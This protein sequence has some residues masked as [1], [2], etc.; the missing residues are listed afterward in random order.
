MKHKLQEGIE[1]WRQEVCKHFSCLLHI[2]LCKSS[3]YFE[4]GCLL[5]LYCVEA[6]LVGCQT[7]EAAEMRVRAFLERGFKIQRRFEY[8]VNICCKSLYLLQM[9]T[10]R[11]RRACFSNLFHLKLTKTKLNFFSVLFHFCSFNFVQGRTVTLIH[12]EFRSVLL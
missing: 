9:F 12:S 4:E 6:R 2:F 5:C 10:Y 3:P 7:E 1:M 8:S 11:A